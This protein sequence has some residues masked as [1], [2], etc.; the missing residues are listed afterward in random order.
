MSEV[1]RAKKAIRK[2]RTVVSELCNGTRKWIMRVPAQPDDDP[3]LIIASALSLAEEVIDKQASDVVPV[4]GEAATTDRA[5]ADKAIEMLHQIA[6]DMNDDKFLLLSEVEQFVHS[7][8]DE[9]PLRLAS[10]AKRSEGNEFS[11]NNVP[12]SYKAAV[13]QPTPIDI[14][15]LKRHEVKLQCEANRL[16]KLIADYEACKDAIETLTTLKS[17]A[18]TMLFVGKSGKIGDDVELGSIRINDV[19]GCVRVPQML[20]ELASERMEKLCAEIQCT[21]N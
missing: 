17:H 14:E 10:A 12:D 15:K 5:R 21:F 4:L 20:I 6:T 1:E 7:I 18:G 2:A 13:G 8:L 16:Q 3:D 9:V 11:K 19:G